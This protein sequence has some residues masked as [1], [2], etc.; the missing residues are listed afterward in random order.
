MS[1]RA[2][3][4]FSLCA[5]VSAAPVRAEER[6][7]SAPPEAAD[8][9]RGPSEALDVPQV[10]RL[11]TQHNPGLKAALLQRESSHWDVFGAE[12][13]YEPVLLLDATGQQLANANV[14]G[15]SIRISRQRKGELG[16]EVQKHL[17]WGTDLSLRIASSV[18]ASS[19]SGGITQ[20][21]GTTMTPTGMPTSVV[22]IGGFGVGNFGPIYGLTAKLT[23]K[24]PLWRGR[25]RA[26]GEATLNEARAARTAAERT[27]ERVNSEL[28]R[29]ALTAY[30]ELWYADAAL[31][32]QRASQAVAARQRE[33]AARRAAS[34]S[35]AAADV[36]AFD[37]QVATRDEDLSSA[38]TERARRVHELA[39]L[40]GANEHEASFALLAEPAREE[41]SFE[42]A[43]SEQRAIENAAEVQERAAAVALAEVRQR[44]ADDPNKPRLDLDGYVQAQG[45]GD[46][47]MRDAANQF[48]GGD[49]VSAVVS[50]TYEAPVRDRVRRATAAKARIATQVA[51]EQLRQTREQV[52]AEVRG[53]LDRAASGAEKVALAERTAEIAARQLSAEE[54][55]YRSGS[56][57]SLMVLEAEDKLRSA[58]LRLARAHADRA[59]SA[60]VVDH[61]TGELLS[62]YAGP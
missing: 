23:L 2:V 57:T 59:E 54:A 47:S 45:L 17:V 29:D 53:A 61:L 33:D 24:Q 52:R 11:A 51:E 26:V 42:R 4:A 41:R 10:V 22:G 60:L 55:R 39:R 34:G 8:E 31:N 1:S 3:V 40:L 50:L 36:L 15:S 32:I 46:E 21:P 5:L 43:L 14:F 13:K 35:L 58:R 27:G 6:P 44:T 56:S 20:I 62:R 19:F 16:A 7:P 25:G 9:A 37:T 12:A 49:V 30:W 38:R 28:L 48:V 18:Q